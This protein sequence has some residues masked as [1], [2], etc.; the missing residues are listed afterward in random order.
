MTGRNLTITYIGGPTALI[1]FGSVRV[2]T[3][4]TFDPPGG[5][6]TTGPVTLHKLTG[7][8]IPADQLGSIDYVLLSHDHHF[9]NLDHAGRSLL[10]TAKSV[11]TTE[12]GAG[13]LG[14]N[15][16][17]MKPWQSVELEVGAGNILKVVATPARHGPSDGDRGPVVGFVLYYSDAPDRCVYFSGD[18]VWYEAVAE[19]GQR[20]PVKT[21]ILNLGA[22]RVPVV[23]SQHLTMTAEEAVEFAR[24][25]PQATIV[26]L[27]FEGWQHF[28]EG[29]DKIALAFA[30]A[31][32][33]TRL[34]WPDLGGRNRIVQ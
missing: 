21:A 12:E 32:L 25:F 19:V 31:G 5:D 2:L 18:T 14:G 4:P 29:K 30:E 15:S 23:G 33:S 6:Y 1:E 17:G 28:S 10:S 8:A 20:F 13:R 7:P 3:D 16:V 11:L 24:S 22:A 9:D 27:H 34:C 26:P